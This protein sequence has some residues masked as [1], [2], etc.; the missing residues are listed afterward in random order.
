MT[1]DTLTDLQRDH[2]RAASDHLEAELIAA[3]GERPNPFDRY[4]IDTVQ[5]LRDYTAE[6]AE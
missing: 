4:V 6:A 5:A 2:L 1:D 3:I